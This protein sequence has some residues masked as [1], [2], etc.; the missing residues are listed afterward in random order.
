MLDA[1]IF[2]QGNLA[3]IDRYTLLL[4]MVFAGQALFSG[5]QNYLF[6][7]SGEG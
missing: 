4:V 2:Q 6:A 5:L 1:S 3:Q 7:R